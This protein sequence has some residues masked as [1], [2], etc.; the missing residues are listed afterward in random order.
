MYISTNIQ[1]THISYVDNIIIYSF[2]FLLKQSVMFKM[3][4][5][6]EILC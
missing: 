1:Y 3:Y 6:D 2:I 5:S 4:L